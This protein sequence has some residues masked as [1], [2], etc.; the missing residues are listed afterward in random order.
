METFTTQLKERAAQIE[1]VS[2]LVE[3]SKAAPQVVLSNQ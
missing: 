2:A 3:M 1:K